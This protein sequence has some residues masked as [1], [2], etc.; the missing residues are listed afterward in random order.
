[1][2]DFLDGGSEDEITLRANRASFDA[3]RLRNRVH[4]DAAHVD[5]STELCGQRFELPVVLSPVGNSGMLHPD[6][7]LAAAIAAADAGALM[8]MSG[9]ASYSIEEV[10]TAADPKPWYQLYPWL[11]KEFYGPLIDRAAAAGFRGL[12]VTIDTPCSAN[13]ERDVVNEFLPPPRLT[14]RSALEIARHPRWTA[15]VLRERRVVVKLFAEDPQP[16]FW[17]FVGQAR[18][19]GAKMGRTLSRPTWDDIAWIRS[20]W[21]G[22]LGVKGITDPDDATRAVELGADAIWVSNHGGRQLDGAPAALEAL[23]P[24]ADAVGGRACIVLDGGVRRGTDIIKAICLGADAVGVG[25]AWAYG[26]AADGL[27]GVKGALAVLRREL[28]ISLELLGQP[29][30]SALDPTYVVPA[31]VPGFRSSDERSYL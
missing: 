11:G 5:L 29:S 9:G 6:G 7:D 8:L 14:R 23:P 25:R 10:A 26:L 20:R 30:V 15:G 27:P 2:F 17:N 31:G 1:M 28:E 3:V 21:Q 13:R 16:T 24:I 19:A 12:V 4:A 18:R 22:P